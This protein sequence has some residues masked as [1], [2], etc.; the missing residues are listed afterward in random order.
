MQKSHMKKAISLLLL[1]MVAASATIAGENLR[2]VE[3][4]AGELVSALQALEKQSDVEFVYHAAQLKGVQTKGVSGTFTVQEAVRKLIEGTKVHM[5]VDAATGA[6]LISDIDVGSTTTGHVNTASLLLAQESTG[7]GAESDR[8]DDEGSYDKLEEVVVTAQRRAETLQDVPIS[9]SVLSGK[10][11]DSSTPTGATEVLRAVPGF[12]SSV[13]QY[14]GGAAIFSLRGVANA[15]RSG[16]AGTVAYYID[17]APYGFIREAYFPNPNVYD[18]D[19]IEVLS[20]PQG[21]LYGANALN[22]VIR[23]LTND[24]NADDFELKVRGLVS[25]TEDGG[26]NNGADIAVNIPLVEDRLGIRLVAGYRDE[27]G[28]IDGATQRDLNTEETRNYRV[29]IFAAPT[30]T[31][32]INLSAWRSEDEIGAPPLGNDGRR[33]SFDFAQ[34]GETGFD[35]Y[36]IEIAQEFPSFTLTSMT[37]QI[38][39]GSN[40]IVYGEPAAPSLAGIYLD[41]RLESNV[42]SQEFNLISNIGG[43]WRWSAGAFYR[44]AED[45]TYQ[46]LSFRMPTPPDFVI[47]NNNNYGDM[48]ES[49][50]AY[51]EVARRFMDDRFDLAVGL[52]YFHDEETVVLNRAYN[53]PDLVPPAG[54][55]YVL[56]AGSK[57]VAESEAVT[58]RVVVTWL[59]SEHRTFYASYSQGFRSGFAQ[60]PNVQALSPDYTPAEPDRLI[61][62]EIGA[63]GSSD[64]GRVTYEAALFYI[65]WQDVQINQRVILPN[66]LNTSATLNGTS[67]SGIGASFALTWEPLDDLEL[68]ANAS[69]N[70]LALDEDVRDV[71]T[72]ALL[73]AGGKRLSYSPEWTVGAS[74][75]YSWELGG[76][77]SARLSAD[78]SWK[79]P[80]ITQ[81]L[82]AGSAVS[83]DILLA[84]ARFSIDAPQNWT[85]SLF[86][87]NLTDED[88]ITSKYTFTPEWQVRLRPRVIGLQLEYRF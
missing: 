87:E 88:G 39:Y 31:L 85:A 5:Q 86:V 20:G 70:D 40:S 80:A 30:D 73:L 11:L 69:W 54:P 62:Y 72:N 52:R 21:T 66:R 16:G 49:Y 63:K 37:S 46:D 43:S 26:D 45:S 25:M 2:R 60:Q 34:P 4:P 48:S 12:D 36:S 67:A 59:P 23:I 53:G 75:Q 41:T 82:S 3:V 33:V 35:T 56:P 61:N 51:G 22:G 24:A 8:H 81:A 76:G 64:D 7:A 14:G 38:D 74:A 42:F 18:L 68:G 50:A 28:W 55:D 84:N 15:A 58:P 27:S 47:Q 19:R 17:G 44:D 65:D 13:G 79:S 83:D 32:T 71:T 9:I 77:F 10:E 57:Y 6:M 1:N 78:G 29:K